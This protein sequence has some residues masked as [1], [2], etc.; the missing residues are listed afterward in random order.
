MYLKNRFS[1]Q[2]ACFRIFLFWMFCFST[3]GTYADGLWHSIGARQAGMNGASV[4]I[5]DFWNIQNNQAGMADIRTPS[6]GMAYESRFS[7]NA[8]SLRSLAFI[9]PVKWGV[10]GLSINYFGYSL[11]HEM[12][13]GLA[14]ARSFGPNFRFGL[15]LDYLQTAFGEGYGKFQNLTF[16]MGVQA[17][18]T[19]DLCVGAWV[20]NPLSVKL[21]SYQTQHFP[22]VVRLGLAYSFSDDLL[23]TI[24]SEKN[25]DFNALILRAGM[26][27]VLKK[28]F[29]FRIGIG[30]QQEIFSMGF[31]IHWKHLQLDLA[32]RMHASLGFSPQTSLVYTF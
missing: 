2:S 32:A 25:T 4:A 3:S 11:Y 9:M 17:D 13:I 23:V 18:L 20:F 12:K 28:R 19:P 21:A 1:L 27:Y 8:L 6:F 30:N 14:Y 7:I 15:Q 26:E 31:G 24:E 5:H 10:T 22:V 16:E 29:F